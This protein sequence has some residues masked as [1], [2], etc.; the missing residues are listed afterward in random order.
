MHKGPH[1]RA[2][3]EEFPHLS[4]ESFPPYCPD[5]DPVEWL[6]A[7]PKYGRLAR[8]SFNSLYHGRRGEPWGRIHLT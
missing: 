6:W 3:P 7:W 1:V 2:V 5:L 4:V 8:A